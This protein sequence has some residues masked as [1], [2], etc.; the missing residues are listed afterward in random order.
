MSPAMNAITVS[1]VQKS[2]GETRALRNANLVAAM[3]EVHAIVGEN[4]SGKSTLA[5]IISGVFASDAGGVSLLGQTPKNPQHTL[6]LGAA[7]IFQEMMLAEQLSITEN[8]FAGSDGLWR[9]HF[10]QSEKRNETKMILERLSG[11]GIDPD[12]RVADLPLHLKQWIVLGR[13][14]RLNPKVLILDESSAALDLEGTARLHQEIRRLRNGGTCVIIVTHRIAELVK[15]ADRATVLRD[16]VTV[17][18]FEKADITEHNL[19]SLMSADSRKSNDVQRS[20]HIEALSRKTMLRCQGLQLQMDAR[21]FDFS[22][23]AGEIVGVAGLD[24]AGQ[25]EFVRVLAGISPGH[26]GSVEVVDASGAGTRISSVVDAGLSGIA[27]VSGDRKREGIFPSLSTFENF[28]MSLYGRHKSKIGIIDRRNLLKIFGSEKDRLSIKA[29]SPSDRITVLSGGN[30][31]KVLIARAFA[32]HP[33]VIV[34]NDPARGVDIGT[35]QEL[36]RQLIAFAERGGAVVYLSSETEE[37]L[38]F[39]DRVAV[40][41]GMSLF[42]IVA[43]ED[44]GGNVLLHAMF[45]RKS[46]LMATANAME[47]VL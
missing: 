8:M 42:D 39:A 11:Q 3:G 18:D 6:S 17:G 29:N 35:K 21:P 14:I 12:A 20:S 34:L 23:K 41:V 19:L 40:F 28:S 45:G 24:G 38:G 46:N 9:K 15:I 13:A 5:K 25:T 7:T 37:F 27:Y 16:G 2:F 43:D 22:L 33:N 47:H 32:N 10:S 36:Y 4:G 30:Q 31:Q 1:N 26:A 44:L